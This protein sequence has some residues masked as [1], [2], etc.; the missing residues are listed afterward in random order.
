VREDRQDSISKVISS[1]R[2]AAAAG[3]KRA[4]NQMPNVLAASTL[5]RLAAASPS[6]SPDAAAPS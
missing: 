5:A 1:H 4:V 3:S 2:E 6:M